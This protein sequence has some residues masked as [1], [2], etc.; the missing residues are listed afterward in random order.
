MAPVFVGSK[1]CSQ[2]D[3][4]LSRCLVVSA[5]QEMSNCSCFNCVFSSRR[6]L[7]ASVCQ[8][9]VKLCLFVNVL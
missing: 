3:A 9:D 4:C 7:I 5:F 8:E 2:E 6:R 1:P